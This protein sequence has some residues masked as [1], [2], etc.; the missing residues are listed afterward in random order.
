M[1]LNRAT[2]T[3]FLVF[4][5]VSLAVW[6]TFSYPGLSFTDFSVSRPQ[7]RRIAGD[8]LAARGVDPAAFN[9]AT[10]FVSEQNAN[11]YLQKA[12]GFKS[13]K[14]FVKEHDFDMFFWIV[15]FFR[16]QEKEEYR[17]TVSSASGR[18][19]AFR[20]IIDDSAARPV[21]P[22]EVARETA[23]RFLKERFGFDPGRYTPHS[24]LTN[25]FDNRTEYFFSWQK[26]G[27][28]IPWSVEEDTGSGKLITSARVAGGDILAF[29]KNTFLVPDQFE[30][31]LARQTE[32]GVNLSAVVKMLYML[33]FTAAVFVI[34]V[35]RN[36]LA[37]HVTK[38]FYVGVM[39]LSFLLSLAFH[40]NHFQDILFNYKTTSSFG[41][42][43]WQT[44]T[45][46]LTGALFAAV[47]VIM[48]GLSGELLHYEVLGE[49]REGAFLHYIRSTFFSRH[50]T[51]MMCLGYFVFIFMLGI[52]SVLVKIG[53]RHLGVWVEHTW[54]ENLSAAY[55]PSLDAFTWGYKTSFFEEVM[56]RVFA[57]ALGKKIFDRMFPRG[58]NKNL[59][60]AVVCSSVLWGFTHSG[61]PV[62]PM[63]FRGVE[64]TCLGIFLSVTYLRYGIIPVIVGHYLF[65]VFWHSAEHLLGVSP[66]FYF[67]SSLGVLLLPFALGLAAFMAD[68]SAAARPLRWRFNRH[69]HYNL[70]I[71]TT[72]LNANRDAFARRPRDRIKKE[73]VSHG[74]DPAVADAAVE[75]FLSHES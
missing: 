17:L 31:Y 41:S 36:H 72:F 48:P 15:R 10:V 2:W 38:K 69:Q 25:V 60:A 46:A 35:R 56:Y 68:K 54:I 19:T 37:M 71:L 32:V 30:R 66:P 27:V 58:G 18:I 33:L 63:W 7:A 23:E 14:K 8:Y 29:S 67:Y 34:I 28:N 24:D 11:R 70:E 50:V 45:A 40:L 4:A 53:E 52:Q 42:H 39:L 20:H 73:I 64:M 13:L 62:F 9:T 59:L 51:E 16:E 57:V 44:G 55:W 3:L 47:A 75:D 43:F 49:R 21:V 5:V 1:K 74:W 26:K 22:K 65:N 6:F 61:Y 12:V